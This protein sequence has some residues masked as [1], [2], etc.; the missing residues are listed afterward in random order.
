MT[1]RRYSL[2]TAPPDDEIVIELP[3]DPVELEIALRELPLFEIDD[4]TQSLLDS[5]C[6]PITAETLNTILP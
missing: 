4:A 6:I 5:F 3:V 2:W 1:E